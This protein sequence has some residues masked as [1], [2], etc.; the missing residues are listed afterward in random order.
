MATELN[1]DHRDLIR[2]ALKQGAKSLG[3]SYALSVKPEAIA[4][5]LLLMELAVPILL[6]CEAHG[7]TVADARYLLSVIARSVRDATQA[8]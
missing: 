7:L 8:S 1:N 3:E 2:T 6:D 5:A 4:G